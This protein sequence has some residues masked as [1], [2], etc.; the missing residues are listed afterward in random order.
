MMRSMT[1]HQCNIYKDSIESNQW[2]TH[3][4][5]GIKIATAMVMDMTRSYER[6][7]DTEF[8]KLNIKKPYGGHKISSNL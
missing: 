5:Y 3:Q 8:R 2:K 7:R 1:H 4:R 6:H